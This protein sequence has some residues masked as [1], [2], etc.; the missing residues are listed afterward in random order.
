MD[1]PTIE[2]LLA[3][4]DALKEHTNKLHARVDYLDKALTR[5]VKVTSEFSELHIRAED[6]LQKEVSDAF[7]RIQN[8]E[9]KFFPNLASD[10]D[11]LHN[12]IG[13]AGPQP[14]CKHELKKPEK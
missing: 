4:I 7:E 11:H 3:E 6:T 8:I 2:M 12:V 14:E 9:L 10:L 1:T 13:H 5:A